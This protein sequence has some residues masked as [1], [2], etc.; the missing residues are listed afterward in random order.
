M[1]DGQEMSESDRRSVREQLAAIERLEDPATIGYLER[2]GV[3]PGWRCLEVGAGAGSIARW[4]SDRVGP[5]GRVVATDVDLSF[6]RLS[7]TPQLEVRRHDVTRDPLETGAF[8]LVHARN[9][10][11]HVPQRSAALEKM[12]AALK[13]GGWILV[14]EPDVR[15]DRADP[16]APVKLRELYHAVIGIIYDYARDHGVDPNFG[17]RL[18]GSLRRLGLEGVKAEGRTEVFHGGP[19]PR[20]PH[21]LAFERLKEPLVAARLVSERRFDDFM[22]LY[23]NPAFAWQDGLRTSVWGQRPLIP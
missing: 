2:I 6:L 17:A 5:S 15:T 14:E 18:F 3:A 10:L 7:D 13:P 9:L 1:G 8:D 19:G 11:A 20:T 21:Q 23:S 22:A 16:S 4:L 12:A